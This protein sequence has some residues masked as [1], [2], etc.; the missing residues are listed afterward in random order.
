MSNDIEGSEQLEETVAE[1]KMQDCEISWSVEQSVMFLILYKRK[2]ILGKFEEDLDNF[3][4]CKNGKEGRER[5]VWLFIWFDLHVFIIIIEM[6]TKKG[7]SGL[8]YFS[9]ESTGFKIAPKT[10]LIMSLIYIGLVVLL[11]IY[12]KLGT[13]QPVK[14]QTSSEEP[15][16][17]TPVPEPAESAE[18]PETVEPEGDLW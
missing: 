7:G 16:A 12:A 2:M 6:S 17:E 8:K 14:I 15:K 13:T 18:G 5:W 1:G 11:H 9:E 3:C 4:C 10:V